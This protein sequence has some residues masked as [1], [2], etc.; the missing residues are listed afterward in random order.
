MTSGFKMERVYSQRKDEYGKSKKRISTE[1]NDVNKQ[2]IYIAPESTNE[3]K[4]QYFLEHA[5]GQ[6]EDSPLKQYACGKD[7]NKIALLSNSSSLDCNT[8]K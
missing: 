3:S 7:Y 4:A 6:K 5:R 2:R 8:Q 1:A